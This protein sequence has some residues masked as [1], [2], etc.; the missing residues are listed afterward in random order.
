MSK[1]ARQPKDKPRVPTSLEYFNHLRWIDGRPLLDTIDP[2]RKTI[3]TAALDTF[4]PDGIP[5]YNFILAGRGKKNYKSAD[6][7]LAALYCLDIRESIQGNNCLILANTEDQANDDLGLAKKLV[8]FNPDLSNVLE[9]MNKEIRR[10]DGRGSLSILPARDAIGA[11]GKTAIFLGFDEI[12]GYRTHDLL[13]AL[14]PDPTRADA[15]TWITSYDTIYNAPGI[16]LFDFKVIGKAGTDPRMLFSWYSGDFC[17][18]P[19]FAD[20]EPELRANPSISAWPEGRAY[21]DQQRRRLPTH[22]FRRLHL[23]L[24]GSPNGAFLDQGAVLAAVVAGRQMLPPQPGVRYSGFVDM[25]GGSSDDAVLS[26]THKVDHRAVVDLVVRQDGDPPFNPRKAV[27][28]FAA[29]LRQ[30]GIKSVTGD[31]YAGNTFKLDF[32]AEGIRYNPSP[33]TKTEIYEAFEPP[34]N[35]GEIELLDIPKLQEQLLTLVIRGAHVDHQPGDHDDYANAVCGAV[36]LVMAPAV[37]PVMP[38]FGSYGRDG[39]GHNGSFWV[40]RDSHLNVPGQPDNAAYSSEPQDFWRMVGDLS[41]Q[42]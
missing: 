32:E 31:N 42:K 28:K 20:L 25:S 24:P 9:V 21:L 36:Y 39:G 22:K 4:R 12:H 33:L 40:G 15:L 1:L 8:N 10:R 6:L 29:I 34:L 27:K 37:E 3:F 5:Q 13:E 30:Y 14:A 11:H 18:D 2:Y 7:V 35:A 17:T 41:E 26:L 19:A 38:R 23:N 16:P